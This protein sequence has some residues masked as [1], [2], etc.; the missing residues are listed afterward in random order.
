MYPPGFAAYPDT[1]TNECDTKYKRVLPCSRTGGYV[2][3]LADQRSSENV[4]ETP[5]RIAHTVAAP[6]PAVATTTSLESQMNAHSPSTPKIRRLFSST[7]SAIRGHKVGSSLAIGSLLLLTVA[8]VVNSTVDAQTKPSA[9]IDQCE[10]VPSTCSTANSSNWTNGNLGQHNSSYPEDSSVPF[11]AVMDNLVVDSTY[12]ILLEWDTSV[13]SG[14]HAFDYLTTFNRTEASADPCAGVTCSSPTNTLAIP[15]DPN[16]TAAGVTQLGGQVFTIRGGE[17]PGNG[18][19]VVNTGNL[20]DTS[21]CSIATNP[22]AYTLSDPYTQNSSTRIR[23]YFK[24]KASTVVIAW[25]GHVASQDDWGAGNSATDI[26]GSPY[27][28]MLLSFLCSD[29]TNCGTG[30]QDLSMSSLAVAPA[31][32]TTTVEQTTTT[33]EETTTTVEET[34]TTVEET[35]TTVEETTTTAGEESTTTTEPGASTT[36]ITSDTTPAEFP[37]TGSNSNQLWLAAIALIAVGGVVVASMTLRN[38]KWR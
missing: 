31:T 14:D 23:L 25:G 24:A 30:R 4:A 19:S 10:N 32:T 21:P 20:C 9:N 18:A 26:P 16:V 38:K 37:A 33:V 22:S 27:H 12:S 15:I 6:D 1:P 13:N 36:T 35:T 3:T 7:K 8:A 29:D 5:P 2:A 28:M 11:R 17:F 34:T